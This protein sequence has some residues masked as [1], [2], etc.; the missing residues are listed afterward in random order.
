MAKTLSWRWDGV[1][2]QC[3]Y[4][5]PFDPVF[6]AEARYNDEKLACATPADIIACLNAHPTVRAEVL[7]KCGPL[8]GEDYLAKLDAAEARAEKAEALHAECAD[9]HACQTR[10]IDELH[11]KLAESDEALHLANRDVDR[12]NLACEKAAE[13][14]ASAERALDAARAWSE[15]VEQGFAATLRPDIARARFTAALR[16]HDSSAQ[17]LPGGV[18]APAMGGHEVPA[19][20]RQPVEPPSDPATGTTRREPPESATGASTGAVATREVHAMRED[21]KVRD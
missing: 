17:V 14:L 9:M 18:A 15:S 6:G 7:A 11:A 3:L 1:E 5:A 8:A 12:M 13:R 2:F 20:N 10:T 21:R 19:R 16:A 4:R